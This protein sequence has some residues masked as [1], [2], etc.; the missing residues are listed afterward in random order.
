MFDWMT[1]NGS[2]LTAVSDAGNVYYIVPINEQRPDGP[3]SCS[4]LMIDGTDYAPR[5]CPSRRMAESYA[6]ELEIQS[7]DI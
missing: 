4:G 1:L 6:E 7:F 5:K 2:M 3:W